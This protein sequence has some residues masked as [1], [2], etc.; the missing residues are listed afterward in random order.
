[1]GGSPADSPSKSFNVIDTELTQRR[2]AFSIRIGSIAGQI[3]RLTTL[4]A[5]RCQSVNQQF[6]LVVA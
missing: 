4:P 2:S 3:P 1:M 6:A 5:Q